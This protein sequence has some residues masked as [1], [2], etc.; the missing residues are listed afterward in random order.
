MKLR[1]DYVGMDYIALDRII[2]WIASR[3]NIFTIVKI[4]G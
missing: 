3:C 2:C 1:I 4:R